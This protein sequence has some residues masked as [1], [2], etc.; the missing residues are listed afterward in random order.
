MNTTE[1]ILHKQHIMILTICWCCFLKKQPQ[2]CHLVY[3]NRHTSLTRWMSGMLTCLWCMEYVQF[4]CKTL[5]THYSS[6]T[7]CKFYERKFSERKFTSIYYSHRRNR[8]VQKHT[9]DNGKTQ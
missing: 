6:Q 7:C 5:A 8:M 2:T 3:P 9:N 1:N 4:T